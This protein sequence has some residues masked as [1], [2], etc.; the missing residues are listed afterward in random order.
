MYHRIFNTILP[1]ALILLVG[2][3]SGDNKEHPTDLQEASRQELVTA[4]EERDQLLSLVTDIARCMDQIKQMEELISMS[5][6][7]SL[8]KPSQRTQ[9]LADLA[10]L[11]KTLQQRREAL[12]E[13]ETRLLGSSLYTEEMTTTVEAMKAQIDSRS[14]ELATLRKRLA[15]AN[16][17]ISEL[18]QTV[19]S[20]SQSVAEA[21]HNADEA[22]EMSSQL[23]D[24]L[25]TCYYAVG[26]HGELK[27]H[28]ILETAFLRSPRLLKGD[29]DQEFFT[30]SDKRDLVMIPLHS[31]KAKLLTNHPAEA[32]E[33]VN[34]D[35]QKALRIIDPTRF[36]GLSNYLVIEVE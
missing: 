21:T 24:E 1:C 34:I 29:F 31:R 11:Q 10:L 19:D 14:K 26:S 6:V 28:K 4:L 7:H 3:S 16:S 32:Y 22:W 17:Q 18:S 2:C 35:G 20:L 25:N 8:E 5:G 13:L 30:V 33:L 23:A 27:R 36:W 15:Q 9:V 12:A